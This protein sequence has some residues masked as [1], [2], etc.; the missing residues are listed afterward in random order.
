MTG[1]RSLSPHLAPPS[2]PTLSPPLPGLPRLWNI[3][4][5]TIAGANS[6][7]LDTVTNR[8][9]QH[10]TELDFSGGNGTGTPADGRALI[11]WPAARLLDARRYIVAFRRIVSVEGIP[12][13]PSSGFLALR[14]KVATSN[15]A[16]ESARPRFEAMFGALAG[17]GFP[18]DELTLVWDFTTN[19]QAD[20][21]GRMLAMRDDAFARIAAGGGVKY[22]ITSVDNNPDANTTRRVKGTFS[23]PC[24]LNDDAVPSLN[25]RLQLDSVT[26]LPVF[27]KFVVRAA[28]VEGWV[29]GGGNARGACSQLASLAHSHARIVTAP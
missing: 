4:T 23:V 17:V 9:V 15:P 24:Y 22:T 18:R 12:V 26:R 3:N 10:W 14:D 27:Q 5:S 8:P 21:T 7:V 1:A 28:C 13:A 11:L 20:I 29:F 16:L 2:P 19:T 25:S 6:I